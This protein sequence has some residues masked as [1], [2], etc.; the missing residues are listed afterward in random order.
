MYNPTSTQSLVAAFED[1]GFVILDGILRPEDLDTVAAW[2]RR[3]DLR[4]A[5]TRNLLDEAWCAALA[6]RLL[7]DP[8]LVPLFPPGAVAVQCTYF[9]KSPESNW[10]VPP[11]RDLN[12]PV[13]AR[14][15][16]PGWG[17]WTEKE[18]VVHGRPPARV[19]QTMVAVR[20]HLEANTAAN[21]PLR[22]A[23]GSHRR[24]AAD[25]AELIPCQV[26]ALGALVMRPLLTHASSK[27]RSGV[28]RVLHFL[29]GPPALPDGARWRRAV[30]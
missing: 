1:R 20:V 23:V 28:R 8:R 24:G 3:T 27:V 6:R 4:R 19:L 29:C 7:A 13:L 2:R 30:R 14:V 17:G 5:G 12:I 21:G 11:H 16:A 10:L 15:E 9:E 25:E 22:V 18:G 26:D